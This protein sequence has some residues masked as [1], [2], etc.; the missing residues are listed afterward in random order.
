MATNI[1]VTAIPITFKTLSGL[2]STSGPLGLAENESSNLQNVEFDKFGSVLKRNGYSC[3][4]T[5]PCASSGTAQGLYWYTS[6]Y[7]RNALMVNQG[8]IYKMDSLDGIWDDITGAV[9]FATGGVDTYT[10][11]LLHCDGTAGIK[12]ITDYGITGH[13]I[14]C[15]GDAEI[16][17]THKFGGGSV[18][19]DGAGDFLTV[20]SHTDFY[21]GTAD[22][23]I[24][25]WVRFANL[26][27]GAY[28]FIQSADA[29]N[30]WYIDFNSA[31]L[32]N[33][34]EIVFKSAG[35]VKG[36]Y[37]LNNPGFVINTYYHLEFSR[38]GTVFRV[39]INGVSQALQE[40]TAIGVN[41]VGNVS[42]TNLTIGG[43]TSTGYINAYFDEVRISKGIARHTTDFTP[44]IKA[45]GEHLQQDFET[46]LGTVL[47]GDSENTPWQWVVNN[48]SASAMTVVSGLTGAKFIK[49]FQNYCILA[50]VK[51]SGIRYP[52]RFYWSAYRSISSWDSAD[53][54]EVSK[55]DGDEITG[56]KVLGDRLVIY[57]ENS[58]YIILFTGDADMPFLMQKSNSIVGCIAPYSIQEVDNGHIF[59]AQDGIYYFDGM[60]SYKMSD[61]ISDTFYGLNGLKFNIASSI[62]QK[63]KNRYWLSVASGTSLQNNFVLTW[64]SY[65]N[66]W[67]KH[68]GISASA[69]SI[70]M[71]DGTDERPYFADYLGYA[72]RMDTGTDDYPSNG[73]AAIN[74]NY[75]TNWKSFDDICDNKGVPHVYLVHRNESNTV[76]T[77][78]YSYDFYNGDQYTQ[79]FSLF[80]TQ[81]VTALTTRRDLTGRG[82]FV[83]IGFSNNQ[84][85]TSFR[86]DGIGT[87][88]TKESKS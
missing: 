59:M 44:S 11:L 15:N 26:T 47:G 30:S 37:I 28:F 49:R 24:D 85:N 60:N 77:L 84:T 5:T 33:D 18:Y 81:T 4:N 52:S 68:T 17:G 50:N 55:D 48:S 35:V 40:Q 76:L 66:T 71:V 87:Y 34:I 64:N 61:K 2:N 74:S 21:F 29:N 73:I 88:V 75:Y 67:S 43:S 39:F 56:L 1:E 32:G 82:K 57:K 83:R 23:T 54:I 69:M 10:K 16:S 9:S 27:N 41:D 79:T 31:A 42:A 3:L 58:I 51:V 8:K 25:F 12:T 45:Y 86:I 22:F 72:Y 14:T 63:K 7:D 53:W 78:S 70:F 65:L 6:L 20:S 13:S 38:N 80:T 36:N 19:F 62:Y 46:F